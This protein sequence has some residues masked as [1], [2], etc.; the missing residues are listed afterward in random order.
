MP[1]LFGAFHETAALAIRHVG[2]FVNAATARP[3]A[4]RGAGA[5]AVTVPAGTTV[6]APS[7]ELAGESNDYH[8]AA[9][10]PCW[11]VV[12]ESVHETFAG[13]NDDGA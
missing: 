4:A 9:R 1:Q 6:V 5:R 8:D 12:G 11:E 7:W 2:A 13:L 10:L 3:G